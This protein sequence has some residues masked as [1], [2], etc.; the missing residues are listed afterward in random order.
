MDSSHN[1][2]AEFLGTI[3]VVGISFTYPTSDRVG[4]SILRQAL[5]ESLEVC[6]IIMEIFSFPF[7]DVAHSISFCRL[8]EVQLLVEQRDGGVT[9][10]ATCP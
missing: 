4:F 6:V 8:D 7:H 1:E 2:A 5:N 10:P 3:V 9:R